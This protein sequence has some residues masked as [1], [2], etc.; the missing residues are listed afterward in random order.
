MNRQHTLLLE[1][2]EESGKE[3]NAYVSRLSEEELFRS[4]GGDEWT[5]HAI[6][7]HLRDVEEQVFLKRTQRILHEPTAPAVEDFDQEAWN[8]EHYSPQE[9]VK[10]ILA[11]WRKARKKFLG[12]LEKTPDKEWIHYAIHPYYGK[13]SLDW[14]ATHNY[15][16]TLDHLHQLLEMRERE[17]LKELNG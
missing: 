15:S 1:R 10:K 7:A 6:L 5:I 3:L 4:P 11:D 9:P 16:H 8:K 13:I 17:I 2:I 12:L 14:L